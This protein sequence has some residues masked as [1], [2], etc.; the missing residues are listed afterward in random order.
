MAALGTVVAE[1]TNVSSPSKGTLQ[2]CFIPASKSI[3][4]EESTK[5]N[6]SG[7]DL[8]GADPAVTCGST[9]KGLN[10]DLVGTLCHVCAK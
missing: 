6:K 10:S 4:N 3:W 8:P 9:W 5:Y 1:N 2:I 7:V